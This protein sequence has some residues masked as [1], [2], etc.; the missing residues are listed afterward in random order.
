MFRYY[1]GGISKNRGRPVLSGV[2][3]LY[4]SLSIAYYLSV[5]VRW[6]TTVHPH[7]EQQHTFDVLA[8]VRTKR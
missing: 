8:Y 2:R 4:Y 1:P 7:Y 6:R 5:D 3:P